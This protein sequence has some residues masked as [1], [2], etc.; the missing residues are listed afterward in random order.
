MLAGRP[1]SHAAAAA[2]SARRACAAPRRS[3]EL[4][5]LQINFRRGRLSATARSRQ[6]PREKEV[7]ATRSSMR[8]MRRRV[9]SR[10]TRQPT[11]AVH[12]PPSMSTRPVHSAASGS[13]SSSCSAL[14]GLASRPDVANANTMA[15]RTP[16]ALVAATPSRTCAPSTWR[17]GGWPR[18]TR[19][20]LGTALAGRTRQ[21]SFWLVLLA[22][23]SRSAAPASEAAT[24]TVTPPPRCSRS[25][26]PLCVPTRGGRPPSLRRLT[27][28]PGGA[29]GRRRPRTSCRKEGRSWSPQ[30][31]APLRN[32]ISG[33]TTPPRTSASPG[34]VPGGL[35]HGAARGA[36]SAV[37]QARLGAEHA[38]RSKHWPP[39]RSMPHI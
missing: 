4:L 37:G 18:W 35:P 30:P 27:G 8:G 33:G 1:T 12:A 25:R 17:T 7:P 34:G 11:A 9:R 32:N 36:A 16:S 3:A 38:V 10:R 5:W 26:R 21:S 31:P 28:R 23:G 6:G 13:S 29:A 14:G 19:R 39:E 22:L 2:R 20:T 15:V 24:A